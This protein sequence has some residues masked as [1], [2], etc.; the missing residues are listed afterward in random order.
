M[1]TNSSNVIF[2]MSFG[3]M[4]MK[5]GR[6]LSWGLTLAPADVAV[7]LRLGGVRGWR[8]VIHISQGRRGQSA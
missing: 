1:S 5:P 3:G 4:D 2:S 7:Q 6:L 8:R